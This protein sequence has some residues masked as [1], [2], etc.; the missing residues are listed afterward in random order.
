MP[1]YLSIGVDYHTFMECN[2]LELKAFV[3]GY[4]LRRSIEDEQDW[5]LGKYVG[6]A[7]ASI[8]SKNSKYPEKP[9]L[10]GDMDNTND[11]E[12][13]ERLAVAE[14]DCWIRA[15]KSQGELPNT[16]TSDI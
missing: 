10:S 2:P 6:C 8:F 14:M 15:L 5:L 12:A 1:Y 13:N 9:F 4:Q 3:K 7:I 16:L 11:P